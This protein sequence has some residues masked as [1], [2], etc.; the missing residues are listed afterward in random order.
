MSGLFRTSSKTFSETVIPPLRRDRLDAGRD[1]DAVS[2][3]VATLDDDI[4]L[5]DADPELEIGVLAHDPLDLECAVH[6]VHG[7]REGAQGPVTDLLHPVAV[8]LLD[9]RLLQ[10][11]APLHGLDAAPLVRAHERGVV[12]DVGKENGGELSDALRHA[13]AV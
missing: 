11:P 7:A 5:V 13:T 8:V 1:V 3:D 10:P 2:V 4:P 6:R 9:E 12:H